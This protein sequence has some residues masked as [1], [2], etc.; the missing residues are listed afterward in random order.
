MY[1]FFHLIQKDLEQFAREWN[2]HRIRHN[3]AAVS[4]YPNE[5][6]LCLDFKVYIVL[7][8]IIVTLRATMTYIVYNIAV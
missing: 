2:S 1:C 3:T 8:T 7:F 6:L 4:G 5:L